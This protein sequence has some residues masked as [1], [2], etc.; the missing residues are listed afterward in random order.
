MQK[1][2]KYIALLLCTL[3]LLCGGVI[4]AY[5]A[6]EATAEITEAVTEAATETFTEPVTEAET[7]AE[8]EDEYTLPPV[9]EAVTEEPDRAEDTDKKQYAAELWE[10]A[11]KWV[12]ENL[13]TVVGAT[14]ALFTLV[15]GFVTKF[16]FVPKILAAFQTMYKAIGEWHKTSSTSLTENKNAFDGFVNSVSPIFSRM[17]EQSNENTELRRELV[18]L[19]K[20]H[21]KVVKEYRAL[22]SALLKATEIQNDQLEDVFAISPLT[23]NE[24]DKHREAY[25]KKK[26]IIDALKKQAEADAGESENE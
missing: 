25:N 21:I 10:A 22:T 14:L 19:R 8:A 17:M 6:D 24:K 18:E 3:L 26:Q 5:A 9:T 12:V 4:S 1:I 13:S 23:L 16:S 7:E 2:N 15:M 20:E 11:Q